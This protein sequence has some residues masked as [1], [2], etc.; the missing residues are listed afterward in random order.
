MH[1][2]WLGMPLVAVLLVACSDGERPEPLPR[3]DLDPTR[4]TVSGL[5]AGAYLA[6]QLH[7][8]YSDRINGVALLA[9]GPYGCAEG[10]LQVALSRCTAASDQDAP[11]VDALAGRVRERAGDLRLAPLSGLDGDTVWVQ[12]GQKDTIVAAAVTEASA[13]L[14]ERLGLDV[15]RDFD[16]PYAHLLPTAAAGGDCATAAPP[17]IAGC[18]FD[19]A[20]EA[21]RALYGVEA[22]FPP[23]PTGTLRTFDQAAYAESNPGGDLGYLYVPKDCADGARCG[24]HIAL[25]GC[26]QSAEQIGDLYAREGGFNRWADLARVV[27]LYPQAKSS[28]MPLNPKACWDWWGYTG[29]D[30]DT[31]DG[32]QLVWIAEMAA[33]LG[34]PLK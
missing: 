28:L 23:A 1:G 25:H 5:S 3:L 33:A 26:E 7:L 24:L 27:V 10:D 11:D 20:G 31:R 18:G 34:A 17:Y 8:A 4:V 22:Q 30:Y 15:V 16:R 6:H 9:G 32:A 13:A 21:F 12:H 19:A 14:Y 2:R 29:A